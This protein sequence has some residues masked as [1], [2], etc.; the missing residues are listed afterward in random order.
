MLKVTRIYVYGKFFLINKYYVCINSYQNNI[1]L[2][3]YLNSKVQSVYLNESMNLRVLPFFLFM[4]SVN[5]IQV[6]KNV[7]LTNRLR[8]L[9][10]E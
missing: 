8:L 4:F 3:L 9:K 5:I 7:I 6:N 1:I 10:N 2:F